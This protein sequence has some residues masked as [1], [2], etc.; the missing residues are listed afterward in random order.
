M[1]KKIHHDQSGFLIGTESGSTLEK[2][3][4]NY[5]WKYDRLDRQAGNKCHILILPLKPT[6]NSR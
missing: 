5:F 4:I 3:V 1:N 2:L 6:E